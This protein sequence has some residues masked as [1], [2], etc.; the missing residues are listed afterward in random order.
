MIRR[1]VSTGNSGTYLSTVSVR[2]SLPSAASCSMASRVKALLMDP[3]LNFVSGVLG[4]PVSRD[5]EPDGVPEQDLIAL[6]QQDGARELARRVQRLQ[7]RAERGHDLGVRLGPG[8]SWATASDAT[9]P[10]SRRQGN[11]A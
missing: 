3:R 2:A 7:V 1:P 8:F 4:A 10:A 5:A 11:G 9:T 6:G